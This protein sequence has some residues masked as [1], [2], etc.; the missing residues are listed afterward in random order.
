MEFWQYYRIL[1][2]RRW[3]ILITLLTAVVLVAAIDRPRSADY[4]ATATLSVSA[5]D[6]R[7]FFFVFP[8]TQE[9]GRPDFQTALALELIRSRTVADRVVQRLNLPIHPAEL[10]A[11][12][13][14]EKD[15]TSELVRVTVSASRPEQA[16]GYVNAVAEAAATYHQEVNRREATLAREFIEKQITEVEDNL[17]GAEETLLRFRQGTPMAGQVGATTARLANL[18]GQTQQIELTLSEVEARLASVRR[19][20][21]GFTATRS[22]QEIVANPIARQLRAE[23]VQLEIALTSELATRTERHQAVTTLKAKIK[24]VRDRISQE[25]SRVVTSEMILA[26]PVYDALTQSRVSLETERIALLAKREAIEQAVARVR[27]ELPNAYENELENSRLQR[28][29]DV[30]AAQYRDLQQ[31][32]SEVRIKEQ[33][34][35]HRGTLAIVD[36]AKTAQPAPFRG[37]QFQ[38]T[39]AA[40]LGLLAGVGLTFFLEYADTSVKT[41][42]DAER[43][44]G[45]PALATI[46][47]HNPPFDEAYR[48]LRI[49]LLA[50]NGQDTRV[51]AITSP[52]PGSGTS[53]VLMN[54]ARTFA[55]NGDRTIVVDAAIRKPVQHMLFRVPPTRGLTEILR[56]EMT[57][58]EALVATSIPNLSLLPAGGAVADPGRLLG[59][60]ALAGVFS[61]V[62]SRADVVLVDTAA[63][64]AYADIY[65]IAPRV[66][67]VMLVLGAGQ[68]PRGI[69]QEVKVQLERV[70]A[71]VVGAVLNRVKPELADS[72]FLYERVN[73]NGNGSRPSALKRLAGTR[74]LHTRPHR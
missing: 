30:L 37:R 45:V 25:V 38:L 44:L 41:A 72:Y 13:R 18:E 19:L 43:L 11:R 58:D 22:E 55:E 23:L 63:A 46:P 48:L 69:E 1:R 35:Q 5:P 14:V 64:G 8:G 61:A 39:L 53:T 4:Q 20:Q 57:V 70:G 24:A 29:V 60:K 62:Q 7:T 16:V 71:K 27:R 32:L 59:S 33:E 50:R 65:A 47:R 12:T 36:R 42:R 10:Q 15:R 21:R 51:F 49:S 26:N 74:P 28:G 54:L 9:P 2:R 6:Q 67:G 31:R 17:R 66:S 40:L 56:G 34:A 73:G 3:L 52:K 68:T